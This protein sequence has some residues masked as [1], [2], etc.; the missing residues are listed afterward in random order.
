MR[1]T[2]NAGYYIPYFLW[3]TLF[4]VAPVVLICYQSF[5]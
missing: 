3:L 5:F 1:K 2:V 4:V